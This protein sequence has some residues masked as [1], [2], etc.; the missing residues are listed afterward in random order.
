MA[1]D[2]SRDPVIR[3]HVIQH[4]GRWLSDGRASDRLLEELLGREDIGPL[5]AAS[6][7][8]R[9][10]QTGSI[11]LSQSWNQ[12]VN[13]AVSNYDEPM[14][15]LLIRQIT[16]SSAELRRIMS[17]GNGREELKQHLPDASI[18]AILAHHRAESPPG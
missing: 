3:D 7:L 17:S 9:S 13:T 12:A 1:G 8:H 6:A 15:S 4:P 14:Q 18:D 16:K 5:A 11:F 2:Q 10:I